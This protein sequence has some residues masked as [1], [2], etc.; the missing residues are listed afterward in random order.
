[1][2]KKTKLSL[3]TFFLVTLFLGAL[4]PSRAH[5]LPIKRAI[6]AFKL[7]SGVKTVSH[8][9]T[10]A[11]S[12]EN[13]DVNLGVIAGFERSIFTGTCIHINYITQTRRQDLIPGCTSSKIQQ[14]L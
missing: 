5:I 7:F 12:P 9:L 4:I 8:K 13:I 6:S 11:N 14:R 2:I 3:I 10:V 1:M